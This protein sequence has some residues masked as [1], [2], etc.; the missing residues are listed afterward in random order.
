MNL[1]PK[2][3]YIF[4]KGDDNDWHPYGGFGDEK[5][6]T[7]LK[8]FLYERNVSDLFVTGLALDYC[9]KDTAIDAAAYGFKTTVVLDGT[10]AI[11][12]PAETFKLFYEH[13][14]NVIENWD[15]DLY[16]IL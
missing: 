2:D 10:A 12:D 7:G 13:G 4:K 14:I 16:N 6:D 3:F 1:I 11:G 15:L 9:V 8:K 5:K